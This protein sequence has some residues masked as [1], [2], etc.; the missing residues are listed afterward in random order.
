[1]LC[2]PFS[3]WISFQILFSESKNTVLSFQVSLVDMGQICSHFPFATSKR[4]HLPLILSLH[5]YQPWLWHQSTKEPIDRDSTQI[6]THIICEGRVKFRWR[7]G[8][9]LLQWATEPEVPLPHASALTQASCHLFSTQ[10]TLQLGPPSTLFP[11][12]VYFGY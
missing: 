9:S 10:H 2:L 3:L 1:M 8:T 12:R 5:T 6:L 11:L 7:R 4:L